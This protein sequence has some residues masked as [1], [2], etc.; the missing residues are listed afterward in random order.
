MTRAMA[1]HAARAP[2]AA[3]MDWHRLMAPDRYI[4]DGTVGGPG[5]LEEVRSPFQ[6]D[7]DRV[8]YSAAF[9]RLQDKTQVHPFPGTD[10]IRTRLTHSLEVASVGRSLGTYI[11]RHVLG[12]GPLDY[13]GGHAL[14]DADFGAVVGAACLAHDIGNP[15]FGHAGEEAIRH[16]FRGPGAQYLDGAMDHAA[17][18]DLEHFE[19]NAQ[20]FRILTRL[21]VRREHGGMRLTVATL[22][23]FGKYPWGVLDSEGHGRRK[24]GAFQADME[25]LEGVAGHL[26]LIPAGPS[27]W[28]RHPLAY[29]TEAAD[30]I[31]YTVVDIEDGVR[32]GKIAVD[33]AESLLT[34]IGGAPAAHPGE[35]TD[36]QDRV[37]YLRARAIGA[38]IDQAKAV[39]LDSEAEILAGRFDG[40]LLERI[41]R[42]AEVAEIERICRAQVF[43]DPAKLEAEVAGFEVV[44]GL[45][46]IF[47]EAAIAFA[48][49]AGDI[50]RLSPRHQRLIRLL[51]GWQHLPVDRYE[52]LLR[53]TDYVSG[54][55]DRFAVGQFRKLKGLS[56]GSERA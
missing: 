21:Q 44:R 12:K 35:V 5:N 23:T 33:V 45:L 41:A 50:D 29:L 26:G 18:A 34:A 14:T 7:A 38:L 56:L 37:A 36:A 28:R 2:D 24:F 42:R 52:L 25:A 13:E 51:P 27:E 49:A 32:A 11:G 10:Y 6:K 30:D 46:D 8:I 53:L 47:A 20:G 54:M 3:R 1:Q 55:T 43:E 16:W 40:R 31:C 9:R 17:K 48:D 15:P 22:G 19:G 39:F 4:G